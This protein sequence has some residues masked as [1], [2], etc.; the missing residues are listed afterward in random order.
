MDKTGSGED[1]KTTYSTVGGIV[2]WRSRERGDNVTEQ[3]DT[4]N[5]ADVVSASYDTTMLT[6]M[7]TST[8]HKYEHCT[9]RDGQVGGGDP[10]LLS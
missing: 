1:D 4:N 6:N 7:L 2:V 5:L 9:S 3:N 10:W 8:V